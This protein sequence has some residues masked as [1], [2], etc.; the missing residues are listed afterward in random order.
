MTWTCFTRWNSNIIITCFVAL[1]AENEKMPECLW[2]T[3]ILQDSLRHIYQRFILESDGDVVEMVHKVIKSSSLLKY[4]PRF[5]LSTFYYQVTCTCT[6]MITLP[7]RNIGFWNPNRP[8]EF[9]K[10]GYRNFL[11]PN[12]GWQPSTIV[13]SIM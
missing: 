5:L 4:I 12:N 13:G 3:P 10:A 7:F 11:K 2:L 1:Q 6:L 9:N 8:L